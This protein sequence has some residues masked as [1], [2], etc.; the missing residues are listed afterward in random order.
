[1]AEERTDEEQIEALK[2]WWA[3]NGMKTIAAIVLVV[4]G[5]FG[6]E[7]WTQTV[8]TE[9]EQASKIWQDTLAIVETGQSENS[10]N[11]EQKEAINENIALLK[12]DHSKTGYAHFAATLKAK[13]AVESGDLDTAATEL[14]WS[15]DN[16]PVQATQI[17]VKLRLA[18]VEAA[19]GNFDTALQMLQG[20]DA[21][22]HKAAFDEARGD[23]HRQLGNDAAAY[24][25]YES[26]MATSQSSDPIARNVLALKFGQVRSASPGPTVDSEVVES[27]NSTVME[28]VK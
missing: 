11:E 28:T 26:A 5:Y 8:K 10:L 21:G 4:G 16:R 24:T 2:L 25:A 13:L 20:V 17:I 23:F 7:S 12:S 3:E 15:L 27:T 1:M 14:Q 18:R 6:W 22:A 19:R 9:S